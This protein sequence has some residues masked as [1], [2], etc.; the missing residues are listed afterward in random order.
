MPSSQGAYPRDL[1]ILLKYG[2]FS[3]KTNMSPIGGQR[4]PGRV[5]NPILRERHALFAIHSYVD[6][7]PVNHN[8]MDRHT[9]F[10]TH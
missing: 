8:A 6:Y 5:S 4:F 1:L 3:K 9:G 7:Q 2:E 10:V